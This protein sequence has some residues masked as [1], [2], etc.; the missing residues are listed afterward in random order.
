[1][2]VRSL[3]KTRMFLESVIVEDLFRSGKLRTEGDTRGLNVSRDGCRIP[4]CVASILRY[5]E[6]LIFMISG[7]LLQNVVLVG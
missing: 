4:A 5:E 1:M 2:F 7:Q 3:P 6:D